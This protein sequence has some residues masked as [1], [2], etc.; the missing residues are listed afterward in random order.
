MKTYRLTNI[1]TGTVIEM[2]FDVLTLEDIRQMVI[3][4]DSRLTVELVEEDRQ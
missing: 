3:G 1:D 2:K 4:S